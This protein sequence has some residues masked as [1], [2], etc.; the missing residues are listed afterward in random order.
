MLKLQSFDFL[1]KEKGIIEDIIK[2]SFVSL[3]NNI[4]SAFFEDF[5][6]NSDITL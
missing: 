5:N 4:P 1:N 6:F 2:S 3:T